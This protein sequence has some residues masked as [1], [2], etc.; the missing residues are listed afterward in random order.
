M[1]TLLFLC[2]LALRAETWKSVERLRPGQQVRIETLDGRSIHGTFGGVDGDRVVVRTKASD[3]PYTRVVV[4]R[5]G[6]RTNTIGLGLGMASAVLT[7][8]PNFYTPIA[9]SVNALLPAYRTVY[10]KGA[11]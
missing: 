11:R 3:V 9:A 7:A 5:I 4:T 1:K 10:R 6:V 2:A 8:N